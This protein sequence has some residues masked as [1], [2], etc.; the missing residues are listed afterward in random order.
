MRKPSSPAISIRSAVSQRRRAISSFSKKGV[1]HPILRQ[2][3]RSDAAV[4]LKYA[5]VHKDGES[6]FFGAP[7]RGFVDHVLL[8]PDGFG[9]FAY[10][11]LHDFR[12]ELGAA[13]D[14]DDVHR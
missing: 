6:R 5:A 2:G 13:K 8:H 9:T 7:P 1:P 12:D 4:V 14:V 10:G 3:S 11:C